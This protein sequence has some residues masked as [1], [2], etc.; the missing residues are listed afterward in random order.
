MCAPVAAGLNATLT[1]HLAPASKVRPQVLVLEKSPA[2]APRMA[3]CHKFIVTPPLFASVIV[4]ALLLV[5]AA[6]AKGQGRR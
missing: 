2:F 5:P 4:C 6:M 1:V 3:I